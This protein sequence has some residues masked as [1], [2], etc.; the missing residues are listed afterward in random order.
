MRVEFF[1]E[2]IERLET[3]YEDKNFK[4]SK[5]RINQWYNEIKDYNEESFEKAVSTVLKTVSYSPTMADIFKT[6]YLK[7]NAIYSK[8]S[9]EELDSLPY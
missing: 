4:M 2:Q 8:I 6:G 7:K 3:E 1:K 5:A 9:Q